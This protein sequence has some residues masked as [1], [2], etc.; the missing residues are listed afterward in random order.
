MLQNLKD[1]GTTTLMSDGT[2]RI[3][4]PPAI[5]EFELQTPEV[6][7]QTET[8]NTKSDFKSKVRTQTQAVIILQCVSTDSASGP[9]GEDCTDCY[10]STVTSAASSDPFNQGQCTSETL[11]PPDQSESTTGQ[12]VQ[13]LYAANASVQ[14]VLPTPLLLD[15]QTYTRN[16]RYAQTPLS[17]PRIR[18]ELSIDLPDNL[19]E[20]ITQ[21][22][23]AKIA[24]KM[25]NLHNCSTF[26]SMK[27]PLTE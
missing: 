25:F 10:S 14:P 27:A 21:T 26:A 22:L 1:L 17:V 4:N 3:Y 13:S 11:P 24:V 2:K 12:E 9:R 6:K 20:W 8:P 18:L 5:S 16:I 7:K 15:A 23:Q 19:P